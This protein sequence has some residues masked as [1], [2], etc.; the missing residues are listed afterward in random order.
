MAPATVLARV[1][2][3]VGPR[4]YAGDAWWNTTL[5]YSNAERR[6]FESMPPPRNLLSTQVAAAG[7]PRVFDR[8]LPRR[9][10][11]A[12]TGDAW[13]E[14]LSERCHLVIEGKL[15]DGKIMHIQTKPKV[16]FYALI[17]YRTSA[18]EWT[19]ELYRLL[20]KGTR[21]R[22]FDGTKG[23]AWPGPDA[24]QAPG[25]PSSDLEALFAD[26]SEALVSDP[27]SRPLSELLVAVGPAP[28]LYFEPKHVEGAKVWVQEIG[29]AHV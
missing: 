14:W 5:A 17:S 25:H 6:A 20:V 23:V 1:W 27:W 29:R 19:H 13:F 22:P 10:P 15:Y 9:L 4:R 26:G 8:A 2:R 18:S 3:D 16:T 7:W 12:A 11:P 21:L 28:H 24:L